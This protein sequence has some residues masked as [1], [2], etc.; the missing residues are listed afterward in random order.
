MMIDLIAFGIIA[1]AGSDIEP[2]VGVVVVPVG[3]LAVLTANSDGASVNGL[4]AGAVPWSRPFDPSDRTPYAIDWTAL[5][6]T[7]E[8]IADVIS[9]TVSASG[10]DLG[11]AIDTDAARI[12]LID[13]T[14]NRVAMWFTVASGYQSNP[15]F[16][17]DGV[18]VG[19]SMLIRTDA[20]PYREYERTVILTVRQ[21]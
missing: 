16:A 8:K 2:G 9:I 13:A 17:A 6:V 20:D 10:A 3:A 21:L 11:F 12:P 19:I 7:G 4:P 5:L 14:H 15:A 1:T 18:K